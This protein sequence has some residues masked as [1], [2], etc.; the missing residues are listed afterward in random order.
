MPQKNFFISTAIDYPSDKPHLGHALEKIQADVLARFKREKGFNVYFSTGTDEHG[1]KI[2]RLAEKANKNP[3]EFVDEIVGFF[4]KLCKALDISNTDFIRTTEDRHLKAV[5]TIFKKIYEKGDIYKGQYKGLYCVDCE[6]YYFPKDLTEDGCCPVHLKK[7]EE[8]EEEAYFFKLGKYQEQIIKHIQENKNFIIPES[9]RNEI[10]NRLREPLKD[11][12]ISRKNVKWG[13][14]LPNDSEFTLFVWF[15]A[16]TNYL[17]AIG[18]PEEKYK[19]FWPAD[20]HLIGKDIIWHHSVIWVGMLLAADLEL[21]RTILAHGFLTT[22]GQKMSKSL[23]NVIDP[24]VLAEKYGADP[25]RY[26]LLR[27]IPAFD[28]GDFTEEKLKERYNADL[29]NGLGNYNSRVLT[30]AQKLG[31]IDSEIEQGIKEKV[32]AT[33][34]LV[35][36]KIEEFK[37]NEA[38]SAVWELISLGDKYLNE[39][40]VWKI[41]DT[42]EKGKKLANLVYILV[43]VAKLLKVFLPQVS[44]K[45][46]SQLEIKDDIYTVKK[47]ET[48][49]P[50]LTS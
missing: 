34:T 23:G 39:N 37:L 7:P 40:E 13:I 27:E 3:Q 35:D 5:E 20:I 16:L 42:E 21:P 45:I 50:R 43:N 32:E 36:Q 38:I 14:A 15:D 6:T 30:L 19:D 41:S 49:F 47:I 22:D 28:D 33:K 44:E 11:L 26:F 48:L 1:Q 18:Y 24:I 4:K 31:E 25:V 12:D 8:I 46:L 10:L 2:E 29:A 9:K 17:S